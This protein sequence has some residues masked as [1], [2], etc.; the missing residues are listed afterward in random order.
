LTFYNS[1]STLNDQILHT[2]LSILMVKTML[3]YLD[4]VRYDCNRGKD[5]CI[6]YV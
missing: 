6:S 1:I 2:R 5:Y 4:F 3:T